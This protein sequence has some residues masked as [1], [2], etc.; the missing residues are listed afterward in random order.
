MKKANKFLSIILTLIIIILCGCSNEIK[1]EETT[2]KAPDIPTGFV[3]M[4]IEKEYL[5]DAQSICTK[6]DLIVFMTTVL[7]DE[8]GNIVLPKGEEDYEK[9]KCFNYIVKYN[10]KENKLDN[11]FEI[12]DCPIKEIWGVELENDNIIIYSNSEKKNA[13]YDLDMNYIEEKE[14]DVVDE[15]KEAKKSSFYTDMSA[16]TNG[17]CYF[18]GAKNRQYLFFYDNPEELYI[19]DSE[20]THQPSN[21]NSDGYILNECFDGENTKA[22]FEII[23]YKN[24]KE[25]NK[26]S[27]SAKDYGCKNAATNGASIG[28]KYAVCT[29]YFSNDNDE[30]AI[31]KMFCWNYKEKQTNK[32]INIKKVAEVESLNTQNIADIK[33]KFNVDI[34]INENNENIDGMV[35]CNGD[36]NPIIIYDDVM[37]INDFLNSLPDGMVKEI[38]SNYNNKE[39][40]RSGIRLDIVSKVTLKNDITDEASAFAQSWSEPME[41]CFAY[42][43]VGTSNVSHEFMHLMDNRIEDYLSTQD[44]N[45]YNEWFKLNEGFE[46]DYNENDEFHRQFKFDDKQFITEY[47]SSNDKEDRA[48][49]FEYLYTS[50]NDTEKIWMKPEA[51]KAKAD[52]LIKIIREAYPSVQK[53]QKAYWE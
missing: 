21:M 39:N 11:M 29:E 30:N 25:I 49:T 6:D 23:D 41:V 5:T 4:N 19:F 20:K 32:S 48:V 17:Y 12:K 52:Y 53:T 33:E 43:T 40:E 27:I 38:Y 3:E 10:A 14:R 18:S 44:K 35:E 1:Q 31:T 9:N 8:N 36:I 51:I 34:H 47:A 45:L 13:Y 16:D 24:A 46:Q 28:N 42:N 26:A 50:H 2:T 37:Y 7:K 22:D 15:Q